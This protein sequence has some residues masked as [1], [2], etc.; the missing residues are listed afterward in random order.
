MEGLKSILRR[1]TTLSSLIGLFL[2]SLSSA[3]AQMTD[4]QKREA[5]QIAIKQIGTPYKLGG[6]APHQGFD[7]SGLIQYAYQKVGLDIPRITREQ[8]KF[9]SPTSRP[10]P[11]DVV[12]FKINGRTVSHA[13]IYLGNN[14]M[15]HAPSSGKR[16]E[17]T[18]IDQPYWRKRLYK[19]GRM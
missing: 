11:G 2:L 4:E 1:Y 6:S 8:S 10:Q 18:S 3:H 16:V 9:F 7:C 15:V 17:I 12:F 14:K 13:G 19:F 5:I